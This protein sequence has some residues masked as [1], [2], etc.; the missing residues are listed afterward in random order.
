MRGI[1]NKFNKRMIH[2]LISCN[3]EE[4]IAQNMYIHNL[5]KITEELSLV[6]KIVATNNNK[7]L[8]VDRL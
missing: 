4:R 7:K 1:N 6:F 2:L 3:T 8:K 5:K